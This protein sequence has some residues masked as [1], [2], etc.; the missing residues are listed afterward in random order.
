[1]SNRWEGVVVIKTKQQLILDKREPSQFGKDLKNLKNM[2][3]FLL[4][5][6]VFGKT[7]LVIPFLILL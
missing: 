2:A 6:F 7:P 1:L 5:C 3:K 4:F